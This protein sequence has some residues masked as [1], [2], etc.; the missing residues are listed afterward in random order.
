MHDMANAPG[1]MMVQENRWGVGWARTENLL[2]QTVLRYGIPML[3]I[4][5]R[6]LYLWTGCAAHS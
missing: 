2:H 4:L 1:P 6:R 3:R 5:A